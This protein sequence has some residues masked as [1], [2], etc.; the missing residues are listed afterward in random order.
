M[1]SVL[2]ASADVRLDLSEGRRKAEVVWDKH[3]GIIGRIIVL[4]IDAGYRGPDNGIWTNWST[5]YFGK[6]VAK[7]M[8]WLSR[9]TVKAYEARR[10]A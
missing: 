5:K 3:D 6:D 7:A 2:I 10:D 8:R 9:E 1:S 4:E